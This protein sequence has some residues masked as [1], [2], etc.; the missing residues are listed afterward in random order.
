M[1][2]AQFDAKMYNAPISLNLFS[3]ENFDF[4]HFFEFLL[5]IMVKLASTQKYEWI[6][7]ER[8]FLC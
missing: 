3:D 5:E 1:G 7:T 6:H 2:L 8:V 4:T